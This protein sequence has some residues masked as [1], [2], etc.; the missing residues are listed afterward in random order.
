MPC[1]YPFILKPWVNL[2][3]LTYHAQ[4][5]I[6]K[7]FFK[8]GVGISVPRIAIC[9]VSSFTLSSRSARKSRKRVHGLKK[10]NNI[11]HAHDMTGSSPT[12]GMRLFVSLVTRERK[13]LNKQMVL[14]TTSR[15]TSDVVGPPMKDWG[16]RG[17]RLRVW[18]CFFLYV[19]F[20]FCG[21]SRQVRIISRCEGRERETKK[22]LEVT[23]EEGGTSKQRTWINKLYFFFAIRWRDKTHTIFETMSAAKDVSR[24]L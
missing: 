14:Q 1:F 8:M 19:F 17:G 4:T 6:M 9:D 3:V 20:F 7:L 11:L 2:S 10:E 21:S 18:V 15:F 23:E 5:N 13:S 12:G 16:R 24:H 22:R